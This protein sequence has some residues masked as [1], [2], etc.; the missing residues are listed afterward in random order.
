MAGNFLLPWRTTIPPLPSIASSCQNTQ[1]YPRA[2]QSMGEHCPAHSPAQ[3]PQAP[4]NKLL[5]GLEVCPLEVYMGVG[6]LPSL[7][8]FS[9]YL[10]PCSIHSYLPNI[11]PFIQSCPPLKLTV[12]SSDWSLAQCNLYQ[13]C[14]FLL[15]H[16]DTTSSGLSLPLGA[17]LPFATT[18]LFLHPRKI[19]IHG[20]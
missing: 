12:F 2:F 15:P 17:S 6:I 9:K 16:R 18:Q 7:S 1:D 5:R 4:L 20:R 8:N 3:A 10:L 14:P 13:G 11:L 19:R